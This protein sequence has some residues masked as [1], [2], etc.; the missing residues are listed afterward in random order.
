MKT[1]AEAIEYV[2]IH[3]P[4]VDSNLVTQLP[5]G[6]WVPNETEIQSRIKIDA[7][8]K[9]ELDRQNKA[10]REQDGPEC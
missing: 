3:Y 8:I 5:N 7:L 9:G 10:Q 1:K 4:S 2:K 6:D